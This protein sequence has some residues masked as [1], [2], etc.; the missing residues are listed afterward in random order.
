[1]LKYC[2]TFVVKCFLFPKIPYCAM[3][4]VL[5]LYVSDTEKVYLKAFVLESP[6]D[7]ARNEEVS[8]EGVP[9]PSNT[10][11][12]RSVNWILLFIHFC[13]SSRLSFSVTV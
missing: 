5:F 7:N 13:K 10:H 11:L 2:K 9:S 6:K 3:S 12:V 8:M 1:M 4:N